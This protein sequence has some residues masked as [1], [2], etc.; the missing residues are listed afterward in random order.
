VRLVAVTAVI[1]NSGCASTTVGR[2]RGSPTGASEFLETGRSSDRL[3]GKDFKA[4]Q[5]TSAADA[6]REL[7]PEFLMPRGQPAGPA[8]PSVFVNGQYTGEADVLGLIGLAEVMEIRYV[9]A[10]AAK[11]QFGSQCRCDGGVI[12]V[13]TVR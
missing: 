9:S 7:R 11:S 13:R 8:R 3:G 10:M 2:E 4:V 5:G 12:L 1:C 6:V